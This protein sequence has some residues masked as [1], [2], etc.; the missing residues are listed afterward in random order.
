M[1]DSSSNRLVALGADHA[2]FELK[3]VLKADLIDQ[4]Y[5]VLDLGTSGPA[6]VDYPDFGAAVAEAVASGR[7]GLG[8]VVCGTGIGISIAANRN[9]GARAALVHS[10]LEARLAREHNDANILALGARVI[11]VEVA[12]DALK[13]FLTT[14]FAGGRHAG[15]VAKLSQL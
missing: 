4:G 15:R 11:G 10:G 13:A 6:S 3:N 9:P 8:V 12:R 5:E 14:D 2:G 7:A 1:T